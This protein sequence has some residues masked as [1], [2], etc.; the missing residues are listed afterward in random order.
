LPVAVFSLLILFAVFVFAFRVAYVVFA[1][2]VEGF[3]ATLF[4]PSTYSDV[5]QLLCCVFR[6]PTRRLVNNRWKIGSNCRYIILIR[7]SAKQYCWTSL[8]VLGTNKVNKTVS[9][10]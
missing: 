6:S 10:I 2:F 5:Q 9:S 1:I 8:Y 7:L 3:A 4:V